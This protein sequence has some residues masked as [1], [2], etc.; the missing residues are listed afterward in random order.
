M[1]VCF[2]W[3]VTALKQ[4]TLEA[5]QDPNDVARSLLSEH[6]EVAGGV[7]ADPK[8]KGLKYKKTHPNANGIVDMYR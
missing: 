4:V 6:V 5:Q 8:R 1:C 7:C 2:S 3:T